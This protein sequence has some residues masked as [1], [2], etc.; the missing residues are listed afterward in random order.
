MY[1]RIHRYMYLLG[2]HIYIYVYTYIYIY[3]RMCIEGERDVER[4]SVDRRRIIPSLLEGLSR[5]TTHGGVKS[6]VVRSSQRPW[7]G[8]KQPLQR[9]RIMP[10]RRSRGPMGT[11]RPS[12]SKLK[13]LKKKLQNKALNAERPKTGRL[14][15]TWASSN[16]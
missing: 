2:V 16:P 7:T 5:P 3:I 8:L 12:H 4:Q 15:A 14:G 10:P 13:K 11:S 6:P 1:T 9:S